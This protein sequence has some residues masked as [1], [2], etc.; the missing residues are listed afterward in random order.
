[1]EER[2]DAHM[3]KRHSVYVLPA[4]HAKLIEI[5]TRERRSIATLVDIMVTEHDE[6][7]KAGS[8]RLPVVSRNEQGGTK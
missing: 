5:A 8:E 3:I 4:T 2:R 1:M 6:A 7:Y